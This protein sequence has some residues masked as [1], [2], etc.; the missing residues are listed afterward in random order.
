MVCARIQHLLFD[1]WIAHRR[2]WRGDPA[3][4]QKVGD[5]ASSKMVM[6][7]LPGSIA[8]SGECL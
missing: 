1:V 3:R 7:Q 5:R 2:K 6:L 4:L 8:A